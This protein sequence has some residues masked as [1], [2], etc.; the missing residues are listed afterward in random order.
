M[1]SMSTVMLLLIVI[2]VG[3]LIYTVYIFFEQKSNLRFASPK[4]KW[5][6]LV[7]LVLIVI[8]IGNYFVNGQK[9]VDLGAAFILTAF[10]LMMALGRS[11]I[12]ETGI[13]LEGI[14]MSW[15]QVNKASVKAEKG[16]VILTYTR[17]KAQRTLELTD[18]SVEEVEEYLRKKRRLYHF[19]K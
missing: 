2:S 18:T 3:L 13:Y 5:A 11:G 4:S 19:G 7:A 9:M 14:K 17:K 1:D 16:K 15:K 8:G 6:P 10:A 12:G